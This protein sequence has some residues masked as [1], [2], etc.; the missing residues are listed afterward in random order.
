MREQILRVCRVCGL[1]AH[2]EKDLA[3]F[4]N[5]KNRP[6]GKST[7]CTEC[8]KERTRTWRT[9][10]KESHNEYTQA[11]Y[12]AN[13]DKIRSGNYERK[14]GITLEEYNEMLEAQN[15]CCKICNKHEDTFNKQLFVDHCHTTGE[16]RGLLCHNCNSLLGL[17]YDDRNILQK[18]IEYLGDK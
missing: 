9:K 15:N 4:K 10:N 17:A 12:E 2:T 11:Y 3:L 5:A 1:E 6:Y 7:I 8:D 18:A 14:Y 13:K 16:V